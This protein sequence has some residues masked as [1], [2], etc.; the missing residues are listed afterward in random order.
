MVGG[1]LVFSCK[2]KD[3]PGSLYTFR[4]TCKF[5]ILYVSLENDKKHTFRS[6]VN[7]INPSLHI[8]SFLHI[9]EKGLWK[10]LWKKV[11]LLKMSNFTSF[12]NVFYAICI[13]KSVNSHIS[14][15]VCSFFESGMVSKQWHGSM[16]YSYWFWTLSWQW[17]ISPFPTMFSMQFVS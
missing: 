10:T 6:F 4:S 13:L 11:K 7:E 12:H 2:L 9:E 3:L 15:V 16:P 1:P 8:H 17:A 5:H 14:L